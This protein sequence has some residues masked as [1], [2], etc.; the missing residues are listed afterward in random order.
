MGRKRLEK[1]D[2]NIDY[3]TSYDREDNSSCEGEKLAAVCYSQQKL[4][5][6]KDRFVKGN[7]CGLVHCT[8]LCVCNAPVVC[9][10]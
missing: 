8:V 3:F 4:E 1:P 10:Y 2:Q 7:K 9:K 5:P 6:F